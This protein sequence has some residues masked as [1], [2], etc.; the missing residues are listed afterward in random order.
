MAPT[1]SIAQGN[2]NARNAPFGGAKVSGDQH[3]TRLYEPYLQELSKDV[4]WT[5]HR[6]EN[7]ALLNKSL[8]IPLYA[9]QQQVLSDS[10]PYF[11]IF[12]LILLGF[13]YFPCLRK[14]G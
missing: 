1:A 6:L 12:T 13:I 14:S 9:E 8:Q 2:Y 7:S 4:E 5:Y 3:L 10:R 11:A